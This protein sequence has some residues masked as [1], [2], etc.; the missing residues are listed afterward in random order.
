[1]P[2]DFQTETTFSTVLQRDLLMKYIYRGFEL[3][4]EGSSPH[5]L[6][7]HEKIFETSGVGSIIRVL[8]DRKRV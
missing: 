5:L 4:S 7:W 1:M 6:F 8:T 2:L 3:P